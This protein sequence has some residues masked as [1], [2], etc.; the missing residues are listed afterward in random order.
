MLNHGTLCHIML[1]GVYHVKHCH[2]ILQNGI[3]SYTVSFYTVQYYGTQYNSIL[4]N[5]TFCCTIS[6]NVN[7]KFLLFYKLSYNVKQ[8]HTMNIHCQT[9]LN[10]I[11]TQLENIKEEKH[12]HSWQY[13]RIMWPRAFV[14]TLWE[15]L[16]GH[17]Y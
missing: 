16:L 13:K 5:V 4:H 14:C 1:Q 17:K 15:C 10:S 12:K 11:P 9:I 7:N 6:Y 2:T 8:C 3:L